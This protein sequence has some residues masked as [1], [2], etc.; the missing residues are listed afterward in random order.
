MS[1]VVFYLLM[2][3]ACVVIYTMLSDGDE[4]DELRA[5]CDRMRPVYEAAHA[6]GEAE[7]D[8]AKSEETEDALIDALNADDAL[9]C[10]CEHRA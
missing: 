6:W 9:D 7:E 8:S 3:V 5:E 10:E 4:L 1:D 2:F